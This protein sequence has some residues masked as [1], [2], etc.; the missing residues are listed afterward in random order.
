MYAG[1]K[2]E[3]KGKEGWGRVEWVST[4]ATNTANNLCCT[5]L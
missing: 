1:D 2:E 5:K 4:C 3:E